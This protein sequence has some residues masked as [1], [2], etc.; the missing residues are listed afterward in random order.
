[1]QHLVACWRVEE[2]E[3]AVTTPGTLEKGCMPGK[4]DFT[5]M[6]EC[7][8][9]THHASQTGWASSCRGDSLK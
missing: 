8:Q 9:S 4:S 1:M 6:Y 5:H 2:E 7:M 3:E